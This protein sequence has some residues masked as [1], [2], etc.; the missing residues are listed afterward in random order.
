ME[1]RIEDLLLEI[2]KLRKE[3]EK[4]RIDLHPVKYST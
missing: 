1:I 2:A 4:L 3:M